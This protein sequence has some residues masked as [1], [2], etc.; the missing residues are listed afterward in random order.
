MFPRRGGRRIEVRGAAEAVD[1]PRR[2]AYRETCDFSPLEVRVTTTLE[3]A[4][5]KAAFKQ[6]LACAS[7]QE[8]E[9]D[10][11]GVATSA[12][13]ACARLER[14]LAEMGR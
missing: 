13:E 6:T 3:A 7:R 2:F 4:G 9:A 1:P 10:F 5:K 8:R 12:S 14:Y 11:Y